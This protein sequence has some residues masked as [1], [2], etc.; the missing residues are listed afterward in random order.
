MQTNCLILAKA[1]RV[2]FLIIAI[3]DDNT[4]NVAN[5]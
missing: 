4:L 3:D 2:E 1:V 5:Q